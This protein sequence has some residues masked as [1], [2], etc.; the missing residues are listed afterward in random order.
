MAEWLGNGLQNHVQ[1]FDSAWHLTFEIAAGETCKIPVP[2]GAGIFCALSRTCSHSIIFIMSA[3]IAAVSYI[4]SIF[5]AIMARD[6]VP[7][8]YGMRKF[9]VATLLFAA[10][11]AAAVAGDYD[12]KWDISLYGTGATARSLPFWA[13]TGKNG[14]MPSTHGGLVVADADF[15][16][17]SA[18]GVNVYA[19]VK[20]SGSAVPAGMTDVYAAPAI[21]G[22]AS[23]AIPG[24]RSSWNGAIEELYAGLGWKM[25]RLD[26]G[27]IDRET[28]YNGLSLTGGNMLWSGNARNVPGYNLQ[29]KYFEVPGTRGIFSIKANYADYRFIDDRY[30]DGAMLHNKSL[31]FKFRL[32]R[33][34]YLQLGLE[35]WSMWGGVSP[36]YGEQPHSFKDYLRVVCGMSGGS[37]AS[38]SDQINVLG[39][40]RGRELIQID[41]KADA[42]TLSFAHDIPFDDG[43][44]MGFQNFPDGVNTLNLSFNDRDR[45]VTD[46]LYEFVYTK[47][48]SGPHHDTSTDPSRK[49]D[50][51]HILGGRDNYFNN[52]E[53]RSGW[54]NYGRTIGLPLFVPKPVNEDGLALGVCNNRVVA[55]HM[56]IGGKF[57]HRIPYRFKATYSRNYGQYTQSLDLFNSSPYQ[58][59]FALEVDVPK[60]FRKIPLSLSVGAYGDAGELYEDNFGLT[61]RLTYSGE[62]NLHR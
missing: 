21:R 56:G 32:H 57:A 17:G 11:D 1:Q 55:H 25:L 12:I 4:F 44:G 60:L 27:M 7:C 34:V 16:Y 39:D 37:D 3:I 18:P 48:Q 29:V 61:L 54:T 59:S 15:R 52:S 28:D 58:L 42:F 8:G 26:L 51:W 6:H 20:L 41:W 2:I 36:L 47:W 43:S 62:W 40:H 50:E 10:I 45:W 46:I 31:Y 24:T 22:Y 35:Q 38:A 53:Y 30:V 23:S 13:V 33:R 49:D 19:G 9:I 5:A 14:I